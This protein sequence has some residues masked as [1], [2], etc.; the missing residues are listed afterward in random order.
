MELSKEYLLTDLYS[1]GS[2]GSGQLLQG[3]LED[4]TKLEK[5]KS[6][7]FS[8]EKRADVEAFLQ[9]IVDISLGGTKGLALTSQGEVYSWGELYVK[10]E[11]VKFASK[12]CCKK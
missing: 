4:H 11:L 2:G 9:K 12:N 7:K 6:E 3:D 5:I 1:V 10:N 8:E